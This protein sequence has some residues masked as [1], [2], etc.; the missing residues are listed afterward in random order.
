MSSIYSL[1]ENKTITITLNMHTEE[2]MQFIEVLHRE[3]LLKSRDNLPK[4][5]W[6]R[7]SEDN[8]INI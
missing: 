1:R 5:L 2:V 8:I 7:S 6:R 4:K 3:L